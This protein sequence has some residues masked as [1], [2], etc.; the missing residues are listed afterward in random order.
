MNLI[1]IREEIKE[2]M[3]TLDESSYGYSRLSNISHLI[4]VMI[5]MNY[6]MAFVYK[7]Y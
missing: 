3:K 7:R 1:E 2:R 4:K 5:N 6:L